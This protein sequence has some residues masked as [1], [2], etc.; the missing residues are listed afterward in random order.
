ML[1]VVR[2]DERLAALTKPALQPTAQFRLQSDDCLI[3]CAGFE[4]R[5][6][7]VLGNAVAGGTDFAVL[8][9]D[10]L[11]FMLENRLAEIRA[12]CRTAS[13]RATEITYDRQNPAG[14]G[15]L[16]LER[17]AGVRGR[18]ILDVSAMSRLLIVQSLV[19]LNQRTSGPGLRNCVVAYAEAASYPPTEEEVEQELR[20]SGEDP[21]YSVLLLS[22]GVFD[23]TIVPELSCTAIGGTQTRLAAFPTFSTDQL[24]ALRSE[25]APSRLTCIHGVPPSPQNQW[26]TAAIARI[27]RLSLAPP[28]NLLASTLDYRETFDFLLKLYDAHSDRERILLSPTGSKMQTVAVGLFRA[29]MDDVQIV[30]P[31]PKEFRS[32][33]SYTQGVGQLYSLAL[34]AFGHFPS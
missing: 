8:I 7:G 31:T 18:T 22:S 16:L 30:Y 33:K 24:T 5:A 20:Q 4:D 17:I 12:V 3:V 21:L 15:S 6:M 9:I 2:A 19:A 27:N 11:P 1:R 25:L 28:E 10:Y 32:P 14:F 29:F 26:R 34:D 23:V 13:L